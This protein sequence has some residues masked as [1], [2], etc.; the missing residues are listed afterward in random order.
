MKEKE[1]ILQASLSDYWKG[2][3]MRM[4]EPNTLYWNR[5]TGIESLQAIEKERDVSSPDLPAQA[6]ELI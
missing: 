6:A 4:R 3:D 5:R 2:V 1:K